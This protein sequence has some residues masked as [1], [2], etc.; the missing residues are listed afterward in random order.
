MG[1][2]SSAHR[3]RILVVEDEFIIAEDIRTVL[4]QMGYSVAPPVGSGEEAVESVRKT[5]PELVFLDIGLSGEI[6]GFETA[7]RIRNISNVPIVFLT[8]AMDSETLDKLLHSGMRYIEKPFDD[9][10]VSE[11]IQKT[12]EEAYRS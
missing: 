3:E 5:S 6:D 9:L 8:G 11:S 4:G 1:T 2:E 12:L 7:R 10:T